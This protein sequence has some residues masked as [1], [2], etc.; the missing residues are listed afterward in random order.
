[1]WYTAAWQPYCITNYISS[2]IEGESE[3]LWRWDSIYKMKIWWMFFLEWVIFTCNVRGHSS[4]TRRQK[5]MM[6]L[7][8]MKQRRILQYTK[9]PFW[10]DVLILAHSSS[11][12]HGLFFLTTSSL[13]LLVRGQKI[14]WA[15]KNHFTRIKKCWTSTS[16]CVFHQHVVSSVSCA[17]MSL[18]PST[19][20]LPEN[21]YWTWNK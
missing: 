7:F 16:L 5:T 1:M 17:D 19:G 12:R 6:L 18:S 2:R 3:M 21:I 10:N 8:G 11:M 13:T 4:S 9:S 15:P 20:P 14:L